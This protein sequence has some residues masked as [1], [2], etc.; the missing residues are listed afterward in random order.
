MKLRLFKLLP[1]L[2]GLFLF[3][4]QAFSQPVLVDANS[5]V[6]YA[7]EWHLNGG[8][9]NRANTD[10]YTAE[11]GLVLATPTREGY[12]FDGWF[13]NADLS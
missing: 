1:C 4:A 7:I 12:N 9:Q 8:T 5:K 10:T 2:A 3:S 11:D 6:E 13:V